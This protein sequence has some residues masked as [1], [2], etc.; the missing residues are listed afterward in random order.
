MRSFDIKKIATVAA[1]ALAFFAASS[2]AVSAQSRRDWER[3]Q[4]RYAK[5]QRQAE[6][7]R[8]RERSRRDSIRD[9]YGNIYDN[10]NVYSNQAMRS[11]YEQGYLAGEYDRRKRKY[12]Q[13]NVYRSSGGIYPNQGDPSSTDYYYR[14][15]YLQGY[16]DGYGGRYRQY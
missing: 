5:E 14:Q 7:E 6:R 10:R 4:K 1:L 12:G 13:S 3:E 11:G 2:T 9:R 16:E 8:A 15:G